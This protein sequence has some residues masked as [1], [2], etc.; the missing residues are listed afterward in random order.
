MQAANLVP[1]SGGFGGPIAQ[2]NHFPQVRAKGPSNP[3]LGALWWRRLARLLGCLT[4]RVDG[5][6]LR[7]TAW[8]RRWHGCLW[9]IGH[10]SFIFYGLLAVLC[11][12]AAALGAVWLE[13]PC[14]W[15]RLARLLPWLLDGA[16]RRPRNDS[17]LLRGRGDGMAASG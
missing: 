12:L 7:L 13:W 10:A 4:V 1:P 11:A 9:L 5:H 8:P 16:G 6:G 17:D 15:R 3:R 14:R 2:P